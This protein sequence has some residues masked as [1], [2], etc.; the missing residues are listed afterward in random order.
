MITF[1]IDGKKVSAEQ[2]ATVLETALAAG[3]NIPY[4]CYHKDMEPYGGCRLCMVEITE[5][6]FTR[7]HPSCAFF[8][9]D[10]IVVKTDSERIK[11]GRKIIAELL[12]ARCP[13]VDVVKNLAE[14]LGVTETRFNTIDSDCV[15]CGQCVRVC[16]N[17]A[18]VG[19]IDFVNRG[20]NRYVGTPFDLPSDDCIGCGSCHYVCPTGS[21]NME[22]ENALRWRNLP[23]HLRK[24][25]YM[26]M[27]LISDKICPSNYQCWSCEY[28]QRMED[29]AETHPIF[30]HKRERALE[31]VKIAG[32]EIRLDRLYDE[33]HIW[34]KHING[35]FRMGID[36]FS[37]QIIG[38]V[39]DMR[40]PIVN[41]LFDSD[42]VLLEISGNGRTMQIY[43][44][45]E[46]KVVDINPD[47]LDNPLLA[48]MA[49]YERGWILTVE[50]VDILQAS[51]DLLFGRSAKEWLKLES[52]KL[53][54]IIKKETG[55]DL[56]FDD[57]IPKDFAK[58][59]SKDIWKKIH[60]IFF[61]RK[62]KKKEVKLFRIED[63]H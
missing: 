48:S 63:I 32:F 30:M 22:Y 25:R 13:N 17:V 60:K 9:K 15:L 2:G 1:T 14:S 35:T 53:R 6:G 56:P 58:T 10:N 20:R 18:N 45:F 16:R 49:S 21:M 59:V 19:A 38:P 52:H 23:A 11:R 42:D 40:L 24:C 5:N 43:A 61:G 54:E 31:K 4:L 28:D 33:G 26:R 37:R 55:T 46:G 36:D 47:I 29:L 62:K 39:N 7:L 57:P 51:N 41:T 44:P 8:V 3:I 50:P 34:L 12:L 27:G